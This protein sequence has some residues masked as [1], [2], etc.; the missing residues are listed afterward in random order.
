M[1]ELFPLAAGVAIALLLSP[2]EINTK[3]K[4]VTLVVLSVVI[5]ALASWVSGELSESWAYLAFD[6]AQVLLV[7]GISTVLIATWRRRSSSYSHGSRTLLGRFTQEM[8][9]RIFRNAI[10]DVSSLSSP[11][12][13]ELRQLWRIV[14]FILENP[15]L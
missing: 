11:C 15:K 4:V 13:R 7:A 2:R 12:G 3:L 9:W 8:E 6:V 5:G 10:R 1:H 14:T